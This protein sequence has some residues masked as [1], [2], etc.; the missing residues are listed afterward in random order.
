MSDE[1]ITKPKLRGCKIGKTS[2]HKNE[3]SSLTNEEEINF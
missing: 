3:T 1:F 2:I